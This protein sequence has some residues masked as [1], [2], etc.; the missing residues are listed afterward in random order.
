MEIVLQWAYVTST[1]RHDVL[2]LHDLHLQTAENKKLVPN[3]SQPQVK[4][5]L[6]STKMCLILLIYILITSFCVIL[7][8]FSYTS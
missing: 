3:N 4:N 5:S 7:D 8:N 6:Y 1:S 2:V